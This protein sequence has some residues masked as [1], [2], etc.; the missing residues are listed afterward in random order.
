MLKIVI[1]AVLIICAVCVFLAKKILSVVLKREPTE[2]EVVIMKAVGLLIVIAG[3]CTIVL[4][5]LL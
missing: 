1:L 5:D 4:P 3:A 2:M